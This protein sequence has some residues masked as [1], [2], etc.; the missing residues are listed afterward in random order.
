MLSGREANLLKQ[1][2]IK[3][4]RLKNKLS[5]FPGLQAD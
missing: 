5:V 3:K 1:A 2:G 4:A